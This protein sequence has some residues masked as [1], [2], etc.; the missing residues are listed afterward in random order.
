M[1]A[2]AIKIACIVV[3][4]FA[5]TWL[6]DASSR[7]IPAPRR[8]WRIAWAAAGIAAVVFVVAALI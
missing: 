2:G 3:A 7:I 5:V 8:H 4:G 1:L 6:W